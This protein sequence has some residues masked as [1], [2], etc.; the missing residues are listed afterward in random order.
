MGHRIRFKLVLEGDIVV[1]CGTRRGARESLVARIQ[2][3]VDREYTAQQAGLDDGINSEG[4]FYGLTL[5][6]PGDIIVTGID[7]SD[8]TF[9]DDLGPPEGGRGPKLRLINGGVSL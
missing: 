5:R 6:L 3:I 4:L 7:L 1:D 8:L 2:E 9:E